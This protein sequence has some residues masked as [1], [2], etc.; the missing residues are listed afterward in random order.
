MVGM[1]TRFRCLFVAVLATFVAGTLVA[2]T[3]SAPL[4]AS[5]LAQ[6]LQ[7]R[8]DG[9]RDFSADFVHTY[10]GGVLKKQIV[11]RGHVLIKK[12]GKMRWEY[13]APSHKLFVSDGSKMYAYIPEDKQVIVTTVSKEDEAATPML[14]LAGKGNLT[15]DFTVSLV[16]VPA[17]LPR[18]TQ[19]LKL[20]PKN[21]QREY[22]WVVL[23]VDPMRLEIRGLA[24]VDAQG[25]TST[26]AFE[27]LQE[28]VGMADKEFTFKTPRGV[29]VVTDSPR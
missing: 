17:G 9:V 2:K 12:P 23:A 7:R 6:E 29:D 15:R 3:E 27:K 5:A 16:E 10:Q 19:G 13:F 11:E 1:M 18:D 28:N 4:T 22:D 24:S 8:Y 20:I 25:G 14:F 26:L 21:P